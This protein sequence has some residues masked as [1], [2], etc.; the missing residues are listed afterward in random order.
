MDKMS[1]NDFKLS[2]FEMIVIH[3]KDSMRKLSFNSYFYNNRDWVV[4]TDENILT[5]HSIFIN[6]DSA[7]RTREKLKELQE[8]MMKNG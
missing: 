5:L 3:N 7:E 6:D 2:L 1:F 8:W 4:I